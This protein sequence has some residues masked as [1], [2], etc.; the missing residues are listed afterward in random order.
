MSEIKGE[1]KQVFRHIEDKLDGILA[2]LRRY[3]NRYDKHIDESVAYRDKVN[4]HELILSDI[5]KDEKVKRDTSQWK[6]A[7]ISASIVGVL[8]VIATLIAN[9]I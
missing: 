6:I 4:K 1:C 2:Q 9:K 7:V 3:N 8:S 5:G